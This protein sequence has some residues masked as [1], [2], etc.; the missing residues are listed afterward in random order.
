M[1]V[2]LFSDNF[3]KSNDDKCHQMIFGGKSTEATV[4]IG[5]SRINES[6]YEKLFG[7]T[8][9]KKLSI[10][11]MLKICLKRPTKSFMHLLACRITLIPS[12]QKF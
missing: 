3:L 1:L 11:N 9:D 8:F 5:N 7:V 2:K 4:S 6:D 10:K 12:N